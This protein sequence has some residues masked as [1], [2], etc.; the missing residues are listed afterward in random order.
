MNRKIYDEDNYYYHH[1]GCHYRVGGTTPCS[2]G[3]RP[4]V[5]LNSYEMRWD[6]R[7][8][9]IAMNSANHPPTD[10]PPTICHR[11]VLPL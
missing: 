3:L 9:Y 4:I 1:Y 6:E 7:Y 2:A 11:T 8:P 5:L 10:S